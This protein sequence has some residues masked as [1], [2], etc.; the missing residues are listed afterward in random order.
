MPKKEKLMRRVFPLL[1]TVLLTVYASASH[2]ELQDEPALNPYTKNYKTRMA[3]PKAEPTGEPKIFRGQDR[4]TDYQTL[5]E[6]GYDLLGYSSF[7]AADVPPE[8]LTEQARKVNADLA[9]VYT[10]RSG[11]TPASVKLDQAREKLNKPNDETEETAK[12]ANNTFY[13]YFA[14]FWTKLPPPLL[15]VHV[16][17]GQEEG[18]PAKGLEVIAVIKGSPAAA[19]GLQKGDT[20]LRLGEM[21][22]DKPELLSQAAQR[23]AGQKTDVVFTRLGAEQHLAVTLNAH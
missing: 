6:D 8:Q 23:Y 21:Q 3:A 5:L 17:Q 12:S 4:V 22:L 11:E 9:L 7:E 10:T 20:L 13:N 15:G 18:V 14:S 1:F 19:A 16:K 2:A